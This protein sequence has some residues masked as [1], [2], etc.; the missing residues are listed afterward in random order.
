MLTATTKKC[1]FCAEEIQAEAIKCKH[2]GEIL[3]PT[4]RPQYI[5]REERK[6][7][8][9]IAALLSFFIPGAGQIYKGEVIRGLLWIVIVSVGYFILV[10]PGI[11]LHVICIISAASGNPYK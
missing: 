2:C 6:W 10:I 9:G 3:D 1:P 5:V 7:S 4:R 8:P 11:I